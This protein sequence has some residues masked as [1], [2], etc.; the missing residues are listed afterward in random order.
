M[1]RYISLLKEATFNYSKMLTPDVL[2]HLKMS[3]KAAQAEGNDD[4]AIESDQIISRFMDKIPHEQY[5]FFN[6][7]DAE[8]FLFDTLEK[9]KNK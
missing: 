8:E 7:D 3:I 5:K 6:F 4:V 1:K 2:R 9:L